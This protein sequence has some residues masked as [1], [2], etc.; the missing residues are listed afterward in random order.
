MGRD[1][2]K[3]R[4]H[5][6]LGNKDRSRSPKRTKSSAKQRMI[7]ELRPAESAKPTTS[8][9]GSSQDMPKLEQDSS[10]D[11]DEFRENV[12][13][14]LLINKL[15]GKNTAKLIRSAHK[16][17]CEGIGDMKKLGTKTAK[18]FVQGFD[19]KHYEKGYLSHTLLGGNSSQ[20]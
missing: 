6:E 13:N 5:A 3:K 20:K 17:K 11:E 8:K 10:D 16:S 2:A 15:S 1:T 9:S 7:D 19:E 12:C 4:M 18:E 14:L